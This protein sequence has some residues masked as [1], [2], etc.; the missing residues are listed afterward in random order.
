MDNAIL[1]ASHFWHFI[2][3]T[4]EAQTKSKMPK[5]AQVGYLHHVKTMGYQP[6]KIRIESE[7]EVEVFL[8]TIALCFN[9]NIELLIQNNITRDLVQK[10]VDPCG[11]NNTIY[12]SKRVTIDKSPCI[13]MWLPISFLKTYILQAEK[14]F[15]Y[16]Q[17]Y[18]IIFF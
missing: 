9:I 13:E 17:I 10:T 5:Q 6:W 14:V 7:L 12:L 3:P 18:A 1:T 8:R 15:N 16:N 2:I 11:S 4:W